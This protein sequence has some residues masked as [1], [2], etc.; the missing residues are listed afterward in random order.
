MFCYSPVSTCLLL[1]YYNIFYHE[2][3][4]KGNCVADDSTIQ[5]IIFDRTEYCTI[6]EYVR[7]CLVG[8]K[9]SFF[10]IQTFRKQGKNV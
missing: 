4:T 8:I 9:F 5:M 10:C 7:P 2:L 6:N 3:I 1:I